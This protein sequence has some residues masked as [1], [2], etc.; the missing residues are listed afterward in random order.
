M[1]KQLTNA[2][3]LKAAQQRLAEHMATRQAT[4]S[5]RDAI[6]DRLLAEA[7]EC[8]RRSHERYTPRT[9]SEIGH[10]PHAVE[11]QHGEGQLVAASVLE[12]LRQAN[13]AMRLRMQAAA[14]GG[15]MGTAWEATRIELQA[16]V[17][18][19]QGLV[20]GESGR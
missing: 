14:W 2:A 17:D 15:D 1:R 10:G 20:A 4:D 12:G 18:H 6:R 8:E 7:A 19:Y 11:E 13:L 16:R 9:A 5:E 3:M